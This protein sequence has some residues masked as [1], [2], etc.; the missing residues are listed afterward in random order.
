MKIKGHREK[1]NLE[2]TKL[3]VLETPF[4][5]RDCTCPAFH[6]LGDKTPKLSTQSA[7]ELKS[8]TIKIYR[9]TEKWNCLLSSS[10]IQPR[11]LQGKREKE[12]G[13]VICLSKIK[14]A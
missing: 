3:T 9:S 5:M 13:K 1:Q 8:A 14:K 2:N 11:N 6:A 10:F 12:Y 7:D 4:F